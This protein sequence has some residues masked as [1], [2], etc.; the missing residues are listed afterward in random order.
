MAILTHALDDLLATPQPDVASRL[1]YDW[2]QRKRGDRPMPGRGELDPGELKSILPTML[3]IGVERAA[4]SPALTFVCRL[5]GTEI[6]SR[7]GLKLTGLTLDAAPIGE[8]RDTIRRQY[9]TAVREKRPIFCSHN[10]VVNDDRYVEYDRMVVPLADER[11]EVTTLV[12]AVDFHCAY[13]IERGRPPDCTRPGYCD[14]VDRCL[15][16]RPVAGYPGGA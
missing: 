6:D 15:A 8:E 12:A 4:S 1:L 2:W 11:G 13:P 7:L 3:I 16:R 10:I 5:A 14:R 9:E